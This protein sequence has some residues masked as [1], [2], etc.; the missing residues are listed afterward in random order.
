[1]QP[2]S[3]QGSDPNQPQVYAPDAQ[4][5]QQMY[6]PNQ[7]P[8][9]PHPQEYE[10]IMNP[11]QPGAGRKFTGLP[12]GGNSILR[13]VL[14]VVGSLVLLVI[15]LSVGKNL[16]SNKPNLTQYVAIAQ[17]QQEIIHLAK[18]ATDEKSLTTTNKNFAV[19]TQVS[20][21]TGQTKLIQYL[22]QNGQKLNDK[23]LNLKVS[24]STD[25]KL[26]A[27]ATANNYNP[28]FQE[29]MNTQLTNYQQITKQ[30][31]TGSGPK[32]RELLTN[33]LKASDLLLQ[34]LGTGN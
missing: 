19:T 25:E 2:N 10:F 17:E 21:T 7:T 1:M 27:A 30:A 11:D 14:L 26:T 28:V 4:S 24:A 3:P 9:A 8:V 31:M 5:P 33:Q 6:P 34:Q 15:L 32:G 16:L 20:L 18:A 22:R 12:Q 23:T 13:R 29:V